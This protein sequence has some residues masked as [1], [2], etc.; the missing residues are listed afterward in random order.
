LRAPEVLL[1]GDHQQI[2]HWRREQQLRKTL[3][4]RPDLLEGAVL[5]GEDRRLLEAIRSEGSER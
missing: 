2:R 3:K 1:N 4:N 5:S